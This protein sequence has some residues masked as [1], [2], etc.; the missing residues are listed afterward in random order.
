MSF[1]A[2]VHAQAI[3]LNRLSLEMCAVAGSGHPST[4]MS[5]GHIVTVLMFSTMRYSP[6]YPDYPTSD[7]L[8]LSEGHAVPV[9]YAACAKLGVK[10]GKDPENRRS[11]TVDDLKNLRAAES[12]LDGHPNPVEGF[13]LFDAATGSLGQGLSVAGGL[14]AA[15]RLDGLDKRVYCIVG[16][17]ECREGQV[18]E[19][20]DFLV[21]HRLGNVCVIINCNQ[22]GQADRVS[23]Q[24]SAAKIK[25]KLEAYGLSVRTIDGHDPKQIKAALDEFTSKAS[26]TGTPFAIVANT[27]KGWGAPSMAGAG[28]HGKPATGEGLNKALA[29]LDEKR[30]ELTSSLVP[31]DT[32]E[33]QPPAELKPREIRQGEM[34]AMTEIA[35]KFDLTS[36]LQT[37]K[38][39]T[40][41]AYGLALRAL[42]HVNDRVVVLDA[43]VSN[44][45]F[46]DMFKKDAALGSR[47]LECKIAEQN[48]ISVGAGL[49]AAGKIPFCS[50]FAKFATRAYDQ[51]E[52]AINSGANLKVVGSHAGITLAADGPSQMS[53]PDV[54]WFRSWTSTRDHRGNPACYVLQPADA[55][56]AY[57][58]THAMAEYEGVCY[59][60]TLRADTEFIYSDQT[61]FNL[62]G[63]EVLNEGRDVLLCASGYMV[64]EANKAL[65]LLDKAGISATLV[66]LYSLPF[67]T[68]ALLDIANQNNGQIITI[69]DNYGGGI[70]AAVAEA[71]TQSGDAFTLRQMHV[72]RIPKSARTP[73]EVLKMCG[74]SAA[75]IVLEAKRLLQ[76]EV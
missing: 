39:A 75:D 54:S 56:A 76:V 6:D 64:H 60:R 71:L 11:L 65:D 59:M 42:G 4:A 70:G 53:L 19:A 69:E 22:Y 27:V 36:A 58:L 23:E 3:E 40:R 35:K 33:I 37:G 29:E 20:L 68:D 9:V 41:R 43:D 15:A 67:D 66:D 25:A 32:F 61:A 26:A 52:M 55:F 18:A 8:V 7:R 10:V 13:P 72:R 51:I 2:A 74:L 30:V 45:T 38:M 16:D 14:A 1:E 5:L 49:S 21:D 46:A 12:E 62:G 48:M 73:D 44:S 50:T 17:G 63:F 34:V 47:F 31:A 57:A 28:W 24:Q